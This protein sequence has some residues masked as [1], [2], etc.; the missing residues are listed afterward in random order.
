MY[1]IGTYESNV[2]S[3]VAPDSLVYERP[4]MQSAITAVVQIGSEILPTGH[5]G[6]IGSFVKRGQTLKSSTCQR[7]TQFSTDL[8]LSIGIINVNSKTGVRN[9]LNFVVLKKFMT[10]K[11][12]FRQRH[13]R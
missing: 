1:V 8:A 3:I 4:S 12:L 2:P 10:N 11:L 13:R 6:K 9:F 7:T 5:I